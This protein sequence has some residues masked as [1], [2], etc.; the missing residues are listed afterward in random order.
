ME[1]ISNTAEE[2]KEILA[3]IGA[4]DFGEL[5]A[6]IPKKGLYS[7]AKGALLGNGLTEM[8]VVS[9]LEALSKKNKT[10]LDLPSFLGAGAYHHFI[11]AVVNAM[12]SRGEFLTAYT[13]YQPEASQGTLQAAFEFQT[14][15]AELY[16]MDVANASLYA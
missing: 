15:V 8:E 11:P 10:A 5:I 12:I 13:P 9:H 3:A 6:N 4:K 14:L 1:F 2:K 7:P 16:G